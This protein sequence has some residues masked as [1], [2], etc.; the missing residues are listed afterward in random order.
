[1][2]GQL[3]SAFRSRAQGIYIGPPSQL[4]RS[5]ILQQ[6]LG[7]EFSK[8]FSPKKWNFFAKA[9][10]DFVGR[11]ISNVAKTIK[12]KNAC[13]LTKASHFR[14]MVRYNTFFISNTPCICVCFLIY[15]HHFCQGNAVY[16]PCGSKEKNAIPRAEL[17][18]TRTYCGLPPS[19][20]DILDAILEV[21]KEKP[22]LN[23][24]PFLK[25]L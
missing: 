19:H 14:H 1:M 18:P 25:Y 10:H 7:R 5:L 22:R 17:P 9:M 12:R 2:P 15:S 11:D 16:C 13:T 21:E 4:E 3:D 20:E 23:L 24:I 8:R 6:E